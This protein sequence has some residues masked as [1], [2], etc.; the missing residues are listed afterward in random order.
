M[1]G[2]SAS[3]AI[4][5]DFDDLVDPED[6]AWDADATGSIGSTS[7]GRASRSSPTPARTPRRI[8]RLAGDLT[9][10]EIRQF[11]ADLQAL[12]QAQAG[13]PSRAGGNGLYPN[14]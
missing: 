5:Q 6:A 3:A 4:E 10:A 2:R 12:R 13:N 1:A 9:P 7:P 14:A 8:D 11:M